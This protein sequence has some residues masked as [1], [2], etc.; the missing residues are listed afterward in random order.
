MTTPVTPLAPV[1]VGIDVAKLTL[2]MARS[3][4]RELLHVPNDAQGLRTILKQLA[5]IAPARIVLEATGGLEQ[6]LLDA[7]LDAGLPVARVNPGNVRHFAQAMGVLGKTD[8]IDA[9]ILVDFAQKAEVRLAVKSSKTQSELASLVTCRRQLVESRTQQKN[10][11]GSTTSKPARKALLLVLKTLGQQITS[12]DRQIAAIIDADDEFKHLDTLLKSVPGV[13]KGLSSTLI[14]DLEE[15]GETDRRD[16]SALVG[17]AP[18]NRDSGQFRGKRAIRG[19][20]T[21]LRCVLYM[22]TVAAMRFN[23]VIRTFAQRLEARS[24]PGK[25]IIVAC[26]RKLLA[27]LNAMI[28]DNLTWTELRVV[29]A[30]D[31]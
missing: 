21:A 14:A 7:L 24:K 11:L 13:G 10:R 27:L 1:F 8:A 23:P 20:R 12:L 9:R 17:V 6:P 4:T 2:D 16:L 3:D 19:G 5:A 31:I 18:F 30:L 25:V 29:K 26:M 28:R 15:L 22:A